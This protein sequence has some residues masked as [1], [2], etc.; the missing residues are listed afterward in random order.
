M[1]ASEAR[2]YSDNASQCNIATKSDTLV[3][4]A[5]SAIKA[6]A[7]SGLYNVVL[8]RFSDGHLSDWY[9]ALRND[10]IAWEKACEILKTEYEYEVSVKKVDSSTRYSSSY[11]N[12]TNVSWK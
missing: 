4:L 9:S 10:K 3:E 1:K 7:K 12:V 2:T 6:A 8:G 11:C 5:L